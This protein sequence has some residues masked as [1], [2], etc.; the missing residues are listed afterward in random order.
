[1]PRLLIDTG[2]CT[3][4]AKNPYGLVVLHRNIVLSS[5]TLVPTGS[6]RDAMQPQCSMTHQRRPQRIGRFNSEQ[7]VT[8]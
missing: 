2:I 3:M 6:R 7:R 4:H 5:S 8:E 1:M